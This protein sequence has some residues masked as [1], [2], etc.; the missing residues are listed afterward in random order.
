MLTVSLSLFAAAAVVLVWLPSAALVASGMLALATLCAIPATFALALRSTEAVVSRIPRLSTVTVALLAMRATTLRSLALAAT[1]AMAV[2]GSVAIGG[3][4]DDLLSGLEAYA[5]DHA[6]TA[7]I[8]VV[9]PRDN[10]ATNDFR[11]RDL[12]AQ[13]E[14][15]PG[16]AKVRHYRGGFLDVD[17]RRMWVIAR[18]SDDAVMVPASQLVRGDLRAAN[19]R[20]QTGGWI[21]VSD[22]FARDQGVGP[23]ER[24]TLPTP[25]G[26]ASYRIAA[27]T[28]NLGWAPGALI[29][30]GDDY[31]RS[32]AR[33]APTALEVDVASDVRLAEVQ[34]AIQRAMGPGSGLR[35]HTAG[36]YSRQMN[37][38]T[39]QG[40]RRLSQISLLL[41]VGAVL[42][43]AAAMGAAIWQRRASLAALRIQS[44]RPRQ[45][46]LLLLLEAGVVLGA[47]GLTGALGGIYG[48]LGADRYLEVVTGFPIA[49][50]AAGWQTLETVFIVVVVA[51][52]VVA[53]PGWFA[54][55]VPPRLGLGGE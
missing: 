10:Q 32:W 23:G 42:A 19:A 36:E 25:T 22:K 38:S 49:S 1:G 14:A 12:E 2:F 3:A 50:S 20:L 41:L 33:P 13:I 54:A 17:G 5:S 45:L 30:N 47:G 48:Q 4:R 44:F 40:L 53:I 27:T 9:N 28:T 31:R 15:V 18:P 39:R 26:A 37:A 43:M 35:A 52:S 46:W 55:R 11:A 29:L 21:A 6:G 24:V 34:A 8:W 7:D 51:V 16:V